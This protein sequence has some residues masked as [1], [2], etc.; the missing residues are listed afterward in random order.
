MDAALRMAGRV[1]LNVVLYLLALLCMFPFLWM[2][3]TA[4]KPEEDALTN[5]FFYG[6]GCIGTIS[7]RR[8]ISSRSVSSW[9]TARSCHSVGSRSW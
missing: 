8:G 9:S 2:L 3:S 5:K 1:A 7:G 6:Y 4:L